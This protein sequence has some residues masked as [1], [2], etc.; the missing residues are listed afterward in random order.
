MVTR[1]QLLS[2]AALAAI[3]P[4]LK[5]VPALAQTEHYGFFATRALARAGFIYGLP[6]VMSYATMYEQ[7][8]DHQSENFEA[9]FNRIKHHDRI[10]GYKDAATVLPNNDTLCSLVWMDLRAEP[11]VLS[12]PAVS[13]DRYYSILL[14]DGNFYI[15]GYI[16]SRATGSDAGNYMVVGPDWRG[17]APSAIKKVFRSSTQFS[18]ALY[19]TQL[20]NPKDIG[21]ARKV[22]SGY[23]LE[24][25]SKNRRGTPPPPGNIIDFHRVRRKELKKNFFQ[26]LAFAL[27]FA[28][29]Q[30]VEFDARASLAK[31]GVGPGRTF[32]F[33]DLSLTR[34][35]EIASG[36]RAGDRKINRAIADANVVVNG[37]RI[38]G[39]FG[40]RIFYGDNW[41][42][43]AAAARA[44]FYG[45]D[46]LEAV[47]LC[48]QIDE[49]R[50]TLD[51]SKGEYIL[52]FARDALPPVNAFWSLTMY[53]GDSQSLVKNP[54]ERYL[55]NS[56]MLPTMKTD[57]NGGLTI[58]IRHKS[59]GAEREANWLPAPSGPM[60]LG[61][62]LYWPKA[63]PPSI[64][65]I[66]KGTWRP[67]GVKRVS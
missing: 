24:P 35:L 64:L 38:A 16:G 52:A 31:L 22:Q 20:F 41:L 1:R 48:T 54:I 14:R 49:D 63:E 25:L 8:V 11:V 10:P 26:H 43:R 34:K 5:S 4:T 39:Y 46:P 37:W 28:P 67:P 15:Y 47:F 45:D 9:P 53:N 65:P 40:D 27:Q 29:A 7:A 23:K 60:R 12:V 44:D 36:I 6:I 17:E 61:M 50:E 21:N 66:G 62:R 30:F 3:A 33:R 51:G 19:R 13:P 42:L 57:A 55:V 2:T 32:D 58:S 59:P 18:I 56:Y